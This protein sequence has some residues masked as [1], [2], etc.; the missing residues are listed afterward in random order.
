MFHVEHF[1]YV[2]LNQSFMGFRADLSHRIC[3]GFA[4]VVCGEFMVKRGG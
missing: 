3:G 2:L 4:V 1:K